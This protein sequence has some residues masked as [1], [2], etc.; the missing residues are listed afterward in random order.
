VTA[1]LRPASE[2]QAIEEAVAVLE[3]GGVVAIPTE[4]VYGVAVLPRQEALQRLLA[5][6]RRSAD[7]GIA[8]LIDSVDQARPLA[9]MPSAAERLAGRFWPGP[10]TLVLPVAPGIELPPAL[11]GGRP[12]VGFRLPDH[13]VPRRLARRLGPIAASSANVSGQPDATTARAVLDALGNELD[14]VL[15]GGP[16]RAGIPSTV[17]A[18]DA[19]GGEPVILREGAIPA[20]EILAES[21]AFYS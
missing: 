9:E 4:T 1:R 20:S 8:L 12:T 2:P 19:A 18:L 3:R 21:R 14:L 6:K 11:T 7:K 16:V 15:D 13:D 10:L 17:V 5:V